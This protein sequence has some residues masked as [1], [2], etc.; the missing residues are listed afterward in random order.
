M[1]GV[2]TWWVRSKS[3]PRWDGEGESGF[4]GM[5][6]MPEEAKAH[7]EKKKLEL[8]CEPPADVEYGYQKD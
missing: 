8:G 6:M 5:F 4:V 3:D 2:G 7:I 1:M